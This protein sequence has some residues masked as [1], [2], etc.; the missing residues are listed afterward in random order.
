MDD[1]IVDDSAIEFS[2]GFYDALGAGKDLE[3]AV[4]EG[5][6]AA[7]L[8]GAEAPPIVVVK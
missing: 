7:R 6:S 2:R 3:F 4:S 5:I 8:K 1:S